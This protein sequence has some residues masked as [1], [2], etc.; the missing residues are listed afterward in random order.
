MMFHLFYLLRGSTPEAEVFHAC[1]IHNLT[2]NVLVSVQCDKKYQTPQRT[3]VG[4]VRFGTTNR[5]GI[6]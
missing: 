3:F 1:C 4:T 6:F 5:L 2:V